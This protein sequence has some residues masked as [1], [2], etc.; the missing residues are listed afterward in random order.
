MTVQRQ[1]LRLVGFSL[2]LGLG[3]KGA[4]LTTLDGVGRKEVVESE[5]RGGGG[6]SV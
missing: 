2:G 6:S 3:L 4:C 1:R 5:K